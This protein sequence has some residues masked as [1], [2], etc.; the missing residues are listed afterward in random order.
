MKLNQQYR[1]YEVAGQYLLLY[2]GAKAVNANAAFE[3]NE[4]TAWLLKRIGEQEFTQN[5]LV[6]WLLEEYDVSE[7]RAISDV[8]EFIMLLCDK[9]MLED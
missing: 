4:P 6:S 7:E 1:V 3:L 8:A 9:G 2:T 5:D